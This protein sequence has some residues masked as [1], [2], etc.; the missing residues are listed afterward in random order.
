MKMLPL[1]CTPFPSPSLSVVANADAIAVAQLTTLARV[2]SQFLLFKLSELQWE[3]EEAGIN[4]GIK[5]K[6]APAGA[7]LRYVSGCACVC[8]CVSM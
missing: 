6:C 1:P 7:S 5:L 3:E 8:V 4:E 2:A